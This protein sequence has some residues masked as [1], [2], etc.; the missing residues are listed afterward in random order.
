[1][2]AGKRLLHVQNHRTNRLEKISEIKSNLSANT[3]ST[4][5]QHQLLHPFLPPGTVIFL[6]SSFWDLIT[7][8]VKNFFPISNLNCLRHS[9]AVLLSY[10]WLPQ[11]RGQPSAGCTLLSGSCREWWGPP[12]NL[13]FP[14]V[15]FCQGSSSVTLSQVCNAAWGYC[16]QLS[17]LGLVELHAVFSA[18]L[19]SYLND[20]LKD[21]EHS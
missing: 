17:V 7:R 18:H 2:K 11:R 19:S 12:T 14:Q 5:P 4:R 21:Q 9:L 8:S 13:P 3:M 16:G 6:G 1:M 15:L 20:W 10:C